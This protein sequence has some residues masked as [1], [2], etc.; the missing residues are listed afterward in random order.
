MWKWILNPSTSTNGDE[1]EQRENSS[2]LP[3]D[4]LCL[5]DAFGAGLLFSL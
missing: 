3:L 5:F 4:I 2:F 1:I